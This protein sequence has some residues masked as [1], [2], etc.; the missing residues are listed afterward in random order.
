MSRR[1]TKIG[2]LLIALVVPWTKAPATEVVFVWLDDGRML[3]GE[4]NAQTDDKRLFLHRASPNFVLT[5]SAQWEHIEA[6]HAAGRQMT[7]AEF[8]AAGGQ[9]QIGNAGSL[10]PG[11][12]RRR[13]L[14][15][16]R[17]PRWTGAARPRPPPLPLK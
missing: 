5:T 15:D 17:A 3:A 4:V 6:I 11:R 12:R 8:S 16:G 1:L 13:Q 14:D 7:V 10:A 9:A 2:V